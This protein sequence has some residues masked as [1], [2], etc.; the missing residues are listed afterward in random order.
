MASKDANHAASSEPNRPDG[1]DDGVLA[2]RAAM[3]DRM[4]YSYLIRRWQTPL[5]Q[6]ARRYT[7]DASE[8][9]DIVQIVLVAFWQRLSD[10]GS[11]SNV[12]AFLRRATLNACRDWLRRRAVRAFF[13]RASALD[14]R[15]VAQAPEN[16]LAD[17]DANLTLLDSLIS[18]LPESL[19]EPLILCAIEGITHKEA[20]TILG[21]TPKAI[22]NRIARAKVTL[23][24]NWP[25]TG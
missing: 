2:K 17:D 21:I 14:E 20:G 15:V 25:I 16:D 18:K 11:P 1:N 10:V 8:A 22:E 23:R 12:G 7:G 24:K 9:E 13:F 4:A 19:K 5:W 3:G 6:I